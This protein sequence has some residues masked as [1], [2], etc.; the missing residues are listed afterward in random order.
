[1]GKIK[2]KINEILHESLSGQCAKCK[3]SFAIND[4]IHTITNPRNGRKRYHKKC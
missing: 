4:T 2:I 3:K 1:M